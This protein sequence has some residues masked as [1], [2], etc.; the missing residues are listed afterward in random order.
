MREEIEVNHDALCLIDI[1]F[2]LML[3]SVKQKN[4]LVKFRIVQIKDKPK[5]T[6]AAVAFLLL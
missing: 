4:I 3:C 2:R 6:S 1:H 5:I